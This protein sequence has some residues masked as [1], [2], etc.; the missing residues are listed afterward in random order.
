MLTLPHGLGRCSAGLAT[1]LMLVASLAACSAGG[2]PAATPPSAS[3]SV[4]SPPANSAGLGGDAF[5]IPKPGQ[6]DV[7]PIAA[8]AFTAAVDGHHVL[9]TIAYTSGVEPCSILD[10]IAVER[11]SG[12]FAVTLREGRGPGDQVC[13]MIARIMKTQ[14]DLGDL[15]PGTYT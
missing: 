3:P 12:S 2:A 4:V 14:V 11:G 7:H 13:I 1:S 10:T 6:L 15:D 8:D 9:L 5:V